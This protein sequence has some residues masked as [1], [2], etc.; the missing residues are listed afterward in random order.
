MTAYLRSKLVPDR[1]TMVSV[2]GRAEVGRIAPTDPARALALAHTIP[3]AWY[4]AQALSC[5]AE[6]ARES[7]IGSIAGQAI[8]AAYDCS[9]AYNTVAVM[10]WPLRAAWSRGR[11][12]YARAELDRVLRLAPEV[13]PLASRIFALNCLWSGR[14]AAD[15]AFAEPI[16]Q[17]ILRLC[18]PDHH[19]RAARLYRHI[20]EVRE[21]RQAGS[22]ASVIAAMPEGKAKAALARR[23]KL[24]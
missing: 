20:A 24:A 23:F 4:R 10:S 13:E 8:A 17:A 21:Q 3:D 22:A 7:S 16:W 12:A 6:H 14:N 1:P 18:N 9:D 2:H 19:W 5:V 11:Q 15:D